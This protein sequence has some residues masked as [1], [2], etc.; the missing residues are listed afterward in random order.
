MEELQKK[1]SDLTKDN[2][3]LKA[4]VA[5]LMAKVQELSKYKEMAEGLAG[6]AACGTEAAEDAAKE[7]VAEQADEA[8][9]KATDAIPDHQCIIGKTAP[10]HFQNIIFKLSSCRRFLGSVVP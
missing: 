8:K 6:K 10:C 3:S 4:K 9:D 1:C 5:E 7:K 2:E